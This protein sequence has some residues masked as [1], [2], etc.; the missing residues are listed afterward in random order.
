MIRTHRLWLAAVSAAAVLA[1]LMPGVASGYA[2]GNDY[3]V[4]MSRYV[5]TL[6]GDYAVTDGYA[7][8]SSYA[9]TQASASY[10]VYAVT[11]QYA[12]YAVQAA[13]GTITNDLSQQIGVLIVEA[14]NSDFSSLV[15]KYAVMDG[16][17]VIDSVSR[18]R[19]VKQEP[20][21]QQTRKD[22]GKSAGPADPMEN[23][24]WNMSLIRSPLAQAK[25]AGSPAVKVGIL[26]SGIDSMHV[27]F[28]RTGTLGGVSNVDCADGHVSVPESPTASA[29]APNPC[30][31][32][33][34][35]GTHV[36]GIVAAQRNGTGVVG[37]APGVT[38]VPVT[39][40]DVYACWWSAAIDGITYAGDARLN[41]INMSFYTDDVN[42]TAGPLSDCDP[43]TT[44]TVAAVDRAI[45]Y[46][47]SRGV[48]PVAA[49]GNSSE[50]LAGPDFAGC[51]VV[52][53]ESPGVIGVSAI[54][55][56]SSL[57]DYSNYGV[58]SNDVA[59]PGGNTGTDDQSDASD[60]VAGVLSTMPGQQWAYLSGTSMASPHA[61]GVAALI[62][63]KFG[64][65]G[66]DGRVTMKP[67]QVEQ[68]LKSSAVDIGA[69]GYD[70]L[71]GYGRIDALRAI[72]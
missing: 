1:V 14:P 31:D 55:P 62:V 69:K 41:V 19:G 10:A 51:R 17:A 65:V 22:G 56:T 48:T 20:P 72:G 36:A 33:A 4:S 13:G 60:G 70:A 58:G 11:H 40:C 26:D 29:V 7:V 12:V 68:K 59:A 27:D 64:K 54:G 8:G 52:P 5:V 35:H 16:Y 25:L 50:D 23:E 30:I 21:P 46:A 2:V 57:A 32:S 61:A 15:Q 3:A 6:S 67:D 9:V 18:D 53:A 39:V 38:L 28:S 43:E 44:A 45:A 66:S 42:T 37:V 34:F 24:Q 47:R 71:Y 49:L 63:S